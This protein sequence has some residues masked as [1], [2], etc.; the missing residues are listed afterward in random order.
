VHTWNGNGSG[1][2]LAVLVVLSFS[3]PSAA[4]LDVGALY[5]IGSTT[6]TTNSTIAF[7]MPVPA[8]HTCD[9]HGSS[10]S[11]GITTGGAGRSLGFGSLSGRGGAAVLG[12]DAGAGG[13]VN[14]EAVVRD[15]WYCPVCC[16]LSSGNRDRHAGDW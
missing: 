11:S 2:I 14:G 7:E 4:G 5:T 16:G 9:G 3:F 8:G 12:G 15:V 13:E 10:R 1:T 6:R